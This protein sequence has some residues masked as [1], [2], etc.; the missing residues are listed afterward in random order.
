[1]A[2]RWESSPQGADSGYQVTDL[3]QNL[4]EPLRFAIPQQLPGAGTVVPGEYTLVLQA[5]GLIDA[6]VTIPP[7]VAQASFTVETLASWQAASASFGQPVTVQPS[8]DLSNR[9]VSVDQGD[10]Q[11]LAYCAPGEI[12]VSADGGASWA[13]FPTE[14]AESLAETLG[15]T[16]SIGQPAPPNCYSGLWTIL[17]QPAISRCSRRPAWSSAH[18]GLLPGLLHDR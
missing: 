17:T 3:Q 18:P 12:R 10:P 16:L 11:R 6:N 8:A 15:Y 13:A 7:A 1:M 5:V 14:G 2:I 9:V 4:M